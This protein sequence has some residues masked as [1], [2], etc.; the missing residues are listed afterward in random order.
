MGS[1]TELTNRYAS[2]NIS[3]NDAMKEMS[4]ITANAHEQV[5]AIYSSYKPI[6]DSYA[7]NHPEFKL[8]SVQDSINY[9]INIAGEIA[10][11]SKD[12][13]EVVN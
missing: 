5:T 12:E 13:S 1:L 3:I 11:A 9:M 10:D 8:T 4:Q 2:G 7:Q 6:M